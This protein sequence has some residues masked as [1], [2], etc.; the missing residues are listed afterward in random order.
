MFQRQS[1][2][3]IPEQFA[4]NNLR[5]D[6]LTKS[7]G[8]ASFKKYRGVGRRGTGEH[9]SSPY[10]LTPPI[11]RKNCDSGMKQDCQA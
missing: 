2:F 4:Y 7:Y 9:I 5:V 6:K 1:L 11:E 10:S 3:K 8:I